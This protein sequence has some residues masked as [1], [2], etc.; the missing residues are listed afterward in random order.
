MPG[1]GTYVNRRYASRLR[2]G[3]GAA[4]LPAPEE[5]RL[6]QSPVM[7]TITGTLAVI[8][9]LGGF[10]WY[11]MQPPPP[12]EVETPAAVTDDGG[13]MAGLAA[14]GSGPTVVEVYQDFL[15]PHSRS[16]D[17]AVRPILDALV[18]ENRIR[19]VW[20]PVGEGINPTEGATRMANAVACAADDGKLR[21]YADALYANQP[22]P[23]APGLSD[24]ELLDLAGPVGLNA[25]SFAS[26]VRDQRYH[27]WVGVVDTRTV[28]R[29]VPQV[30][31]IYVNGTRLEQPTAG[32]IVAAVG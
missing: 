16:V 21:T 29:G 12:P 22:P 19:L 27:K 6:R 23:G 28:E 9:A 24:N 31:S 2:P 32:A 15:S 14:G 13:A 10:G 20:H 26:C 17:E 30:P 4:R 11:L 3:R 18:A 25:P 1:M 8:V 5:E 7:W